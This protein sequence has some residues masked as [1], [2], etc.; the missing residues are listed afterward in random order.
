[1]YVEEENKKDWENHTFSFSRHQGN[2][3][4]SCSLLFVNHLRQWYEPKRTP[5][6]IGVLISKRS[7]WRAFLPTFMN[8]SV[9]WTSARWLVGRTRLVVEQAVVEQ[10]EAV[11]DAADPTLQT[12]W[13]LRKWVFAKTWRATYSTRAPRRLPISCV[14][15]KRS[16]FSMW[17]PS[18][19]EMLNLCTIFVVDVK[20]V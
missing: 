9:Y 6:I 13:A 20:V 1:M 11:E 8:K 10:E 15:R 18:S 4:L 5:L 14:P 3:I 17:E 16:W 12:R 2:P 19:G 7:P